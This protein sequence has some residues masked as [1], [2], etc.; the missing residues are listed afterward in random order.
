[1]VDM[2]AFMNFILLILRQ[3]VYYIPN[4]NGMIPGNAALAFQNLNINPNQ[5]CLFP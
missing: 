1:M 4:N 3:I 2:E 5:K